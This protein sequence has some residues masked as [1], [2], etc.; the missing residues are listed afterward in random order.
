MTEGEL[1][2]YVSEM[3]KTRTASVNV[4]TNAQN[5][6]LHIVLILKV[7]LIS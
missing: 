4:A 3:Q 1:Q 5:T 2:I 6:L 7:W